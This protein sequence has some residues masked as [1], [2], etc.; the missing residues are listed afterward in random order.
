MNLTKEQQ[1]VR[2]FLLSDFHWVKI[3]SNIARDFEKKGNE[4]FG[5]ICP[6][7]KFYDFSFTF[8]DDEALKYWNQIEEC[9]EWLPNNIL[10]SSFKSYD[11]NNLNKTDYKR[12][13]KDIGENTQLLLEAR[14]GS[15]SGVGYGNGWE[16]KIGIVYNNM[17]FKI[18]SYKQ[19]GNLY[20]F[21]ALYDIDYIRSLD[22][23][24]MKPLEINSDLYICE[25]Y[26]TKIFK[27]T[28]TQN[29][30]DVLKLAMKDD[31]IIFSKEFNMNFF[32]INSP[33]DCIFTKGTLKLLN[34][35]KILLQENFD[36]EECFEIP[37]S[38]EEIILDF[39]S[40]RHNT[41]GI[42]E[43]F[44]D[45]N[46]NLGKYLKCSDDC[47]KIAA[48]EIYNKEMALAKERVHIWFTYK[49]LSGFV[50]TNK[51]Q[52]GLFEDFYKDVS[53]IGLGVGDAKF[54]MTIKKFWDCIKIDKDKKI[55]N[56][57]NFE[58]GISVFGH[59]IGY[60]NWFPKEI[61]SCPKYTGKTKLS[62]QEFTEALTVKETTRTQIEAFKK[63]AYVEDRLPALKKDETLEQ[64]ILK[65][66]NTLSSDMF[67]DEDGLDDSG[68][69][70]TVVFKVGEQF[71]EVD[72][73]CTA[74]W[75]GD[76]SVRKNLPGKISIEDIREIKEFEMEK[77]VH[78]GITIK[79]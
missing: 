54:D 22:F 18:Y 46:K 23:S 26:C 12:L 15:I 65:H 77:D 35:K 43:Q 76:W 68:A 73:H 29:M 14:N 36:I 6:K 32:K 61:D 44:I 38:L 31:T 28:T 7:A 64:V 51:Y 25:Y 47:E 3:E 45:R 48:R 56:K 40:Q 74:K 34:P 10:N 72:L 42:T 59:K 9:K 70:E 1:I 50:A 57:K 53:V 17:V 30:A 4:F 67:Y 19:S 13:I 5:C 24:N 62:T 69:D 37:D 8:D 63:I 79:Y 41:D 66:T 60:T 16:I 2:S 27:S 21:E 55:K 75:I 49:E 11:S 58:K 78:D 20:E 52:L 39:K 71:Y 33:N